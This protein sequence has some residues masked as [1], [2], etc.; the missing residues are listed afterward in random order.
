MHPEDAGALFRQVK[1]GQRG[2]IIYEPVL[3]AQLQDGEILLEAHRDPYRKKSDDPLQFVRKLAAANN[4]TQRIDWSKA[5][6][7]IS[8][9]EGV[10]REISTIAR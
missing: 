7:V 4:L 3:L 2:E 9:N 10:T 8:R 1:V 5:A 6:E